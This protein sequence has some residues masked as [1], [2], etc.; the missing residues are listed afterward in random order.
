MG[1]LAS[2]SWHQSGK[3]QGEGLFQMTKQ[4]Q[5][6]AKRIKSVK[7]KC[8]KCVPPADL[9]GFKI[10]NWI[11]Q[12]RSCYLMLFSLLGDSH[13]IPHGPIAVFQ[14]SMEVCPEGQEGAKEARVHKGVVQEQCS[15]SPANRAKAGWDTPS[16]SA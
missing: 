16:P 15:L 8:R 3:T 14:T 9:D 12:G 2:I 7:D 1:L 4:A 10:L 11:L 5:T 13:L 6:E